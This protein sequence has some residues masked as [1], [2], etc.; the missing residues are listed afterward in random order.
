MLEGS[1]LGEAGASLPLLE[2][3]AGFAPVPEALASANIVGFNKQDAKA[4]PFNLLRSQILKQCQRKGWK[5]IGVTSAEPGAGKSFLSLNL[6]AS[7]ARIESMQVYL[8]DLDLTRPR[9]ASLLQMETDSGLV[10]YLAGDAPALAPLGRRIEGFNLAVFPTGRAAGN[11]ASLLSGD[12]FAELV[13]LLKHAPDGTII[14]CDLPPVLAND[15][16]MI[17]AQSLDAYIV[18]ANS[19]Q[20]TR[21]MLN[22]VY[23]ML[24]PTPRLGTVLN[25]YRGG[26]VDAYGYSKY[27]KGY[28]SYY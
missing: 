26:V 21:K 20:T 4:R 3:L 24:D 7:L 25:R 2:D 18:V 10:N 19:G 16:A 12:R 1:R 11:N 5:V 13:A 28:E 6:A 22:E 8:F 27:G 14:L 9:I 15:D 23:T 17:V